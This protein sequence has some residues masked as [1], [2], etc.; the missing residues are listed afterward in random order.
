M[1]RASKQPTPKH[2]LG[3]HQ[4]PEG[5]EREKKAEKSKAERAEEEE[6]NSVRARGDSVKNVVKFLRKQK[7]T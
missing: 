5:R 2:S 1:K 6:S 4:G 3:F 7:E